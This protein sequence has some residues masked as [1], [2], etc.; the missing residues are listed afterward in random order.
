MS[1]E[2][3]ACPFCGKQPEAP[4][5][6]MRFRGIWTIMHRGCGILPNFEVTAESQE[7][8]IERW[9]RRT[10]SPAVRALVEACR[11]IVPYIDSP[12][13]HDEMICDRQVWDEA[14]AAVEREIGGA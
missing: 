10:P 8:A 14:L 2:L 1:S 5:D 9:N 13:W 4:I 7:K 12:A 11:K 6:A 3:K